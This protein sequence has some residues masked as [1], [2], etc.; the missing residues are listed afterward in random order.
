MRVEDFIQALGADYFVGVPDSQLRSLSDWL[1]IS[2]GVH[3]QHHTVATNEG[4]AVGLAAGYH[5]ATGKTPVVYMQNS[6]IGNAIN[7]IASLLNDEVYAIP[8]I[9]VIGWRG[10]PGTQ[11]EPQHI[12]QG[13]KTLPLL[14]EMDIQTF[15]IGKSTTRLELDHVMSS[16]NT[17]LSRGKQ[18]AFVIEKDAL[19]FE[20]SIDYANASILMREEAIREIVNVSSGDLIVSTT[21]KTSRELFEIREELGQMHK[22]DFLTVGSMGHSAAIALGIA[23]QKPARTVWCIDGDGSALMHLGALALVGSM[24]LENLI[25]VVIN[26]E[27]HESVGGMPTIAGS[28]SFPGIAKAC[29]YASAATV[30]NLS[31]LKVILSRIKE[32]EAPCFIE[33]SCKI[34]AR[35]NLG[36]PTTSP[37]NNKEQ[38]MKHLKSS[39][40]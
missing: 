34:G 19:S 26:N 3:P 29:G 15:V 40:G 30:T 10:R 28:I 22:K 12:F 27:A 18:V 13:R 21:G 2:H 24:G 39:E 1:M 20:G 32:I 35:E 5:L 25:H 38:F 31:E 37:C 17:L 36:R 7:P 11:D 8:C 9:F 16:F 14:S 6:G 4:T 23:M 33:I